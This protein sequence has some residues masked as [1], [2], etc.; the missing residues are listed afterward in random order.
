MDD[1]MTTKSTHAN[2]LLNWQ[3]AGLIILCIRFVQGF[4]FWGGGSRRFIY[5]PGKLDPY[6]PQWMANKLQSAMPGALLDIQPIIQFLLQHFILLYTAIILFSLVELISG[7][8][9]ITGT[10][11]RLAGFITALLSIVLMILFGWEGGTCLDEWTMAV[12]NL[13]MGLTIAVAGG[14]IYSVDH[15]LLRRFPKL[16]KQQWFSLF[17]SGPLSSSSLK[18]LSLG[19][20]FFTIIFTLSTYNYY[21]GA[22]FSRYHSGPVSPTIYHLSLSNGKLQPDGMISFTAYADAG[23]TSQP[24]YIMRM[25]L[26]NMK[27]EVLSE[28]IAARMAL[29]YVTVENDYDYN[30]ITAGKYGLIV[31]TSA[32]AQITLMPLAN[33]HLGAGKYQLLLFTIDGKRWSLDLSL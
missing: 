21:R 5:A 4:I 27:G 31:P 28:W 16:A 13:A 11:T 22:I 9:L 10:F 32:K 23:T 25:E 15:Y 8:A 6:A 24:N 19:F 7:I 3:Q 12:S 14:G 20:L 30:R 29:P 18:K 2:E 26:I 17:T 1:T 33:I